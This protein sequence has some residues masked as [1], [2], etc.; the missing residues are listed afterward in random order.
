MIY[1]LVAPGYN[2]AKI[3][4]QHITQTGSDTFLGADMSTKLKLMGVD[5]ASIGDCHARTEGALS[6]AYSDEVNQ[7]YKKIVVS[8]DKKLLLGVVMI[9]DAD[10]YG[11]L[12]QLV[13]NKIE[14]PAN[15]EALILPSMD[16]MAKPAL[17]TDA[18]PDTAQI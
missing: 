6:Y 11:N 1:G 8:A 9:G 5:V 16:G 4:A 13:L 18:L 15:P 17:G 2:M 7:V 12:L 3:A 10:D 14:L